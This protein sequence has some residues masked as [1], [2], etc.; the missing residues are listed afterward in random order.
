[1]KQNQK[2]NLWLLAVVAAIG[3]AV[4]APRAVGGVVVHIGVG[5]P[6]PAAPVYHYGYYPE[7]EVYFVPDS[8]LYWW[9]ANGAWV[10]GPHVPEGIE[11]GAQVQL[12]VDAPEPWHHHE[13]IVKQFPGHRH[14]RDRDHDRH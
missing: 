5:E 12:D 11:L 2:R 14:D 1:M 8:H 4:S 13:V 7:A 10:S 9:M 3:V 6:V